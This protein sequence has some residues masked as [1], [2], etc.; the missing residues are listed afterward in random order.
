MV[1]ERKIYVGAVGVV[2]ILSTS[3][4]LTLSTKREVLVKKPDGTVAAWTAD[5]A[6]E[7]EDEQTGDLI[8]LAPDDGYIEY[9]TTEDDLDQV[10]DYSLQ[11][12]VEWGTPSC[13]YGKTVKMEVHEKFK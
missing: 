5:I 10:G 9:I 2:I 11:A 8:D 4:D 13:H 1:N 7:R 6:T 12:Y 3:Q